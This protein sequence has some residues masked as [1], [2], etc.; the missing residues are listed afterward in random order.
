MTPRILIAEDAADVAEVVSFCVRLTWPEAEVTT[1]A[2]GKEALR[3]LIDGN[4]DIV[5]LDVSMPPPD[6]FEVCRRIREWGTDVRILML[7]VRGT[8]LDKVRG[9]DLGADDYLTKPF[10]PL[11]LQARLRALLRRTPGPKENE[12]KCFTSGDLTIDFSAH[13]VRLDNEVVSLTPTEFRLLAELA[14]HAGSTLPHEVLRERVWGQ[15]RFGDPSD[16]KVFIRRLR[17]KLGDD[18]EQPRYIETIRGYGYR[19]LDRT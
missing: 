1:V 6:G 5:I 3:A 4:F 16:L 8:T 13:E 7:T 15:D 18:P 10:D 12:A 11:E 17:R 9:F 14:R 2:S 19:F